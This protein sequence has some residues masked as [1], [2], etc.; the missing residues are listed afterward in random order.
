M[1]VSFTI[2]DKVSALQTVEIIFPNKLIFF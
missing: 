1:E 2:L